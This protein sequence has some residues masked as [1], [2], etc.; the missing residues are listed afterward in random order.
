MAVDEYAYE[1]RRSALNGRVEVTVRPERRRSWTSEQK[2]RIVQ[3]T[4]APGAVVI[5]IARR[6]GISTGLLYTW[7]R[8]LLAGAM[9]GF[10]PVEVPPEPVSLPAPTTPSARITTYSPPDVQGPSSL[11]E[12]ELPSGIKL[13]VD[14][15]IDEAVLGRV[16]AVLARQ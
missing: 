9:S 16:L 5:A 6:Y 4:L 1:A 7:R 3:E 11:I 2:L 15:H 14:G 12:V 10:V 13:R 8:Q